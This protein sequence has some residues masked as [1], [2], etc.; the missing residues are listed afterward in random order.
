MV[1]GEE[2]GGAGLGGVGLGGAWE[3]GLIV[4]RLDKV[5]KNLIHLYL[6]LC[7]SKIDLIFT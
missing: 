4:V 5:L 3:G 2:S 1:R 7:K 6:F